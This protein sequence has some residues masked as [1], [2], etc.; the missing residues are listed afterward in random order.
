MSPS[1]NRWKP[2]QGTNLAVKADRFYTKDGAYHFVE[3]NGKL[4]CCY[5]IQYTIIETIETIEKK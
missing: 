5:P 4:I 2:S 3:Q 1:S